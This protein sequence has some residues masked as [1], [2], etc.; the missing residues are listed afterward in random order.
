MFYPLARLNPGENQILF[1][2]RPQDLAASADPRVRQF[3]QGESS[4]RLREL[5]RQEAPTP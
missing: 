2:G 1:D 5:A 4:D 3:V